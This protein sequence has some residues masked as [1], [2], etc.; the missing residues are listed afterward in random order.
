MALQDGS[1]PDP[2]SSPTTGAA[3]A[4]SF[5]PPPAALWLRSLVSR[6]RGPPPRGYLKPK[7]ITNCKRNPRVRRSLVWLGYLALTQA[8]RVRVPAAEVTDF[9]SIN[10]SRNIACLRTLRRALQRLCGFLLL[11]F[12]PHSMRDPPLLFFCART[13][14]RSKQAERGRE[15]Q[16][17]RAR[18]CDDDDGC[19]NRVENYEK[20]SCIHAMPAATLRHESATITHSPRKIAYLLV[21]SLPQLPTPL[22]P[23]PSLPLPSPSPEPCTRFFSCTMQAG[24]EAARK[25]KECSP[26]HALAR[27]LSLSLTH[28]H[29]LPHTSALRL[30][31]CPPWRTPP[32]HSP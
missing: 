27:S 6:L 13:H 8:T 31:Q 25:K 9:P 12:A 14:V 3:A 17:E 16:R 1:I 7:I 29:T 2:S 22:P 23:F 28:T 30:P 10:I 26:T 24:F 20:E 21:R 19:S 32:L 11:L 4:L 18:G 15:R 5:A